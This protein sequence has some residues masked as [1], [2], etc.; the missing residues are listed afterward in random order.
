MILLKWDQPF[1]YRPVHKAGGTQEAREA[2]GWGALVGR[3]LY[4]LGK[5][6]SCYNGRWRKRRLNWCV[7]FYTLSA[8]LGNVLRYM[9]RLHRRNFRDS[10]TR[11]NPLKWFPCVPSLGMWIAAF[12]DDE[13]NKSFLLEVQ[14]LTV[15]CPFSMTLACKIVRGYC[16]P[17]KFSY[18]H[19]LYNL[20]Y[21]MQCFH[22]VKT[23]STSDETLKRY[24]N[25]N[26]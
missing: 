1:Q 22:V 20:R 9:H 13:L 18:Q 4:Q 6:L 26:S 12:T 16:W 23:R 25:H 2:Q 17:A 15:T 21:H 5:F 24:L 3:W 7:A 19:P 14:G 10:M 8:V 11:S